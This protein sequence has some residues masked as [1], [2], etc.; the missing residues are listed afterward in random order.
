MEKRE[1]QTPQK[2]RY[3]P[4]WEKFIPV[5]LIIIVVIIA[6]LLLVVLSVALGLLPTARL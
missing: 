2:R 3:P 5:A 6:I 4:F 1:N